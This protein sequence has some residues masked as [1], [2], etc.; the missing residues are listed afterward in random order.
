MGAWVRRAGLVVGITITPILVAAP[1]SAGKAKAA[2]SINDVSAAEGNTGTSN[3]VFTISLSAPVDKPVTVDAS[4]GGGTATAGTDYQAVTATVTIPRRQT[5]ATFTVPVIGDTTYEPDETFLVTLSNPREAVL[6]DGSGQGIIVNDDAAPPPPPPP[7]SADLSLIL[8][9]SPDP[10][11]EGGSLTYTAAVYQDGP[12]TATVTLTDPLPTTTEFVSASAANGGTCSFAPANRRVV[13]TWT[14]LAPGPTQAQIVVRP[15]SPNQSMHNTA[16][17][18]G[19]VPDPDS[20]FNCDTEDSTV[21]AAA[22]VSIA[23]TA[24]PATVSPGG[25][26]QYDFTITNNAGSSTAHGVTVRAIVSPYETVTSVTPSAGSCIQPDPQDI[27]C[28]LG[29]LA[30]GATPTVRVTTTANDTSECPPSL[31]I[32]ALLSTTSPVDPT[33]DNNAA[34]A[35]VQV[36]CPDLTVTVT[37]DRTTAAIGD[38][39][40]WTIQVQ[41]VGSV[42]ANNVSLAVPV[43]TGTTW[44]SMSAA[45]GVSC[46]GQGGAFPNYTSFVCTTS[47]LAAGQSVSARLATRVVSASACGTDVTEQPT[48][49]ADGGDSN[50]ANNTGS[51]SVH[52]DL[53]AD[54][55]VSLGDSADP[56]QPGDLVTYVA[57]VTNAAG[58]TP[59][60]APTLAVT[61]PSSVSFV[62]ATPDSGSC[63]VSGQVVTCTLGN[64]DPGATQY[65]SITV[66]TSTAGTIQVDGRVSSG[67]TELN[68]A[69]NTDSETTRVGTADLRVSESASIAGDHVDMTATVTNLGSSTAGDVTVTETITAMDGSPPRMSLSNI[70]ASEGTCSLIPQS[71]PAVLQVVCTGVALSSGE[72]FRLTFQVDG[73][74]DFEDAFRGDLHAQDSTVPDPN[75]AN[76]DATVFVDNRPI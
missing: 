70:T 66:Q 12:S 61:L 2:L 42:A 6:G 64:L 17:V 60:P 13:C 29:D 67:V 50:P 54:L 10:V 8:S 76:N 55:T 7:A 16:C 65:V 35:S 11:Y 49:T 51:A 14:A 57:T 56:V 73:Y 71:D 15:L 34:T 41:N 27:S 69:D 48:A 52:I 22:D 1:A 19:S 32:T 24:S 9:D 25:T 38:P 74:T 31:R 44:T 4:T 30:P 45:P 59:G 28:N 68:A 21:L 62:S 20:R 37:P 53:C 39:V 63:S 18:A 72:T 23:A 33:Q 43:P 36:A 58:S 5:S 26:V 40:S 46:A 47:S 3:R 75:P